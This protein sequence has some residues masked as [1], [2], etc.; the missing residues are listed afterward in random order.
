ML[1]DW[2]AVFVE[3]TNNQISTLMMQTNNKHQTRLIVK[4]K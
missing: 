1:K 3:S 2:D 4:K